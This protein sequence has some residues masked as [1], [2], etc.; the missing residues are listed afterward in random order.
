MFCSIDWLDGFFLPQ[1]QNII[2]FLQAAFPLIAAPR[3]PIPCGKP[4]T[5][6][7]WGGEETV[8]GGK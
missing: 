8:A 5:E 7:I 1:H 6:S 2:A 3:M 4:R